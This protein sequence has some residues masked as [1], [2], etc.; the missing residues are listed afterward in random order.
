MRRIFKSGIQ[1]AKD[2]TAAGRS[3]FPQDRNFATWTRQRLKMVMPIG[4]IVAVAILCIIIAV[5]TAAHRADEMA[6]TNERQL[7][8]QAL[9]DAARQTADDIAS[10]A[11]SESGVQ[12]IQKNYD[13]QWVERRVG[14]W[15]YQFFEI[16]LAFVVNG[17]AN[18]IFAT[19]QGKFANPASAGEVLREL[20]PFM[21]AF[22]DHPATPVVDKTGLAATAAMTASGTRAFAL[23]NILNAPAIVAIV[24]VAPAGSTAHPTPTTPAVVGVK[25]IDKA[26]L[27]EIAT[28]LNLSNLRIAGPDAINRDDSTLALRDAE[29][30]PI[31]HMAWTS[32]RPGTT[33]IAMVT[34]FIAIVFAG[35]TLMTVLIR[36]YVQRTATEIEL[37]ETQLRYL[38]MHDTLSGLPNRMFFSEQLEA[39]IA[40]ANKSN[41]T[42]AVLCIDLD[43]F[44]DINDTLGHA[45]GDE[46]ILHVTARLQRAVRGHD[47]VARL[48]G[49][50]F[51]IISA[52]Q[53][54]YELLQSLGSRIVTMLTAPYAVADRT[55]TIG[56]SIG[57]AAID[58]RTANASDV[59]RNADLALYRAKSD[60]LNRVCIYDPVMDAALL[61][62][63]LMESDLRAAIADNNLRLAY[64][65]VMSSAGDT[66]IGI[67]ALAR[68]THPNR[69][70]VSPVEFIP[71]AESSG[72]I[73]DLESWA[74]R[75][76][77]LDCKQWP[78][79][80]LSINVS[81][82]QFRRTDFVDSVEQSLA[83][84][85][86]DPS[87]L[88]LEVTES[89]FLG[90]MDATERAM[91]R[92]KALGV[93]LALDDFGTGY[94]SLLYLRRFP[95]DRIK[96]DRS[97]VGNIERAPD[98]AAIVHAV[99]GLG[100]GLGMRVTAEG[101]ETPEQHMFLRAAGV[102]AMQGYLFGQPCSAAEIGA[103][104]GRPEKL[105]LDN[106]DSG[107][108]IA[109]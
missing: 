70:E 20:Q 1:G 53:T 56:A 58:D 108:A 88:E 23:Q 43:H 62:R 106:I 4:V 98:A 95:F 93:R 28:L 35:L 73:V 72:L 48:G 24:A 107:L 36:R 71:I 96:I 27:A 87:Q 30:R 79:V 101:V 44:K 69:G 74:L 76:A 91:L 61:D 68:W 86:F 39:A 37:G 45:I 29:N 109:S 3:A 42:A 103:R 67:E 15:L 54:D 25:F 97:F 65:P 31:A 33:M 17:L 83:L 81:P 80:T 75:Q 32:Q 46:L 47:L 92:L 41:S 85:G 90:N 19:R 21:A 64:Q 63:K 59:M 102:H 77:C 100:R 26:L 84:T 52:I 18:P 8:S 16:D 38:A 5:L 6:V 66:I 89:T 82:L 7:L 12:N 104:L 57:I 10:V 50:E 55:I 11:S 78:G 13:P 49:D 105:K 9:L 60:G 51:A 14:Q 34:P 99:V 40:N 2:V 94:S 22:Y